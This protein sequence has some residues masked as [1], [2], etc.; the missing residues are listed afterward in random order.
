[1]HHDPIYTLDPLFK[2]LDRMIADHGL[3]LYLVAINLAPFAIVWILSGGFL[4]RRLRERHAPPRKANL[5]KLAE[6]PVLGSISEAEFKP[7]DDDGIR[8]FSA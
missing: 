3:E 1:M 4:R 2:F 5:P 8:W 6:P 7:P